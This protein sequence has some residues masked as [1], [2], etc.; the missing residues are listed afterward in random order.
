MKTELRETLRQYADRRVRE[1]ATE[2]GVTLSE[3]R[4][5]YTDQWWYTERW[6]GI[7]QD[8]AVGKVIDR[9]ALDSLEPMHRRH[10]AHDYPRSIPVGYVFPE[11]R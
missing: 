11:A 7:Q 10:L 9:R 4:S 2:H 5:L 3:V 1:I 8:A 6:E